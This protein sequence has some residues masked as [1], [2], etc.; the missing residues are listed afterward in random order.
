MEDGEGGREEEHILT[1]SREQVE[2]VL[3]Q[4]L[5]QSRSRR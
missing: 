5:F 1:V 4:Y 2:R 3:T